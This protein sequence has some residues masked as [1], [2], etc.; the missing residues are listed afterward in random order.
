MRTLTEEEK[1]A[2]LRQQ[3]SEVFHINARITCGCGASVLAGLGYR[4]LYCSIF[5]CQA[6]AEEHFGETVQAYRARKLTALTA[7]GPL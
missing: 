4:C 7:S 5:M 1:K 6:C 3:S 2:V